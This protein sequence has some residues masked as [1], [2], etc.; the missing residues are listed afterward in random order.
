MGILIS[1]PKCGRAL[2]APFEAMGRTVRCGSC[3]HEFLLP[4]PVAAGESAS[5]AAPCA[6]VP[7]SAATAAP[8][9]SAGAAAPAAEKPGKVAAIGGMRIGSGVTNICIGLTCFFCVFPLLLVPLGIVEIVS[10]ANLLRGR[11]QRPSGMTGL[12]V[13]E[14]V[15]IICG[16][17]V[18]LVVGILS[19]V[20]LSDETVKKYL[21]G[22]ER[23]PPG[24]SRQA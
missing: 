18:S 7:P 20:F 6:P 22:L 24:A 21:A 11:P 17:I 12:C 23:C 8:V 14:I 1:C 9:A 15:A 3:C 5:G 19:L 2:D 16:S 4:T 10:G 13:L